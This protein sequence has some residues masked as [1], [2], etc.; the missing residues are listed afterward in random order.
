MGSNP[1]VRDLVTEW[2][3][4]SVSFREGCLFFLSLAGL[5]VLALKARVRLT[6]TELLWLAVFGWLA[7]SSVRAIVWWGL[8]L[9]PIATRLL[10][11]L[12]PDGSK[13]QT[14]Q[15]KPLLNL[16]IFAAILGMV[17]ASLPWLKSA[18]PILPED[19]RALVSAADTPVAVSEY[20]R[21][22]PPPPGRV[23]THLAWGGYFDWA[24]WP[25]FQP[26]LDGRIEIHPPQVWLDYLTITF[27]GA[28][29]Q[30][31][32]DQYAVSTVVL[33]RRAE[34]DLAR[35]LAADPGWRQTYE[36]DLA[37]VFVRA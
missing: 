21:T 27:P 16:V 25:T 9:A 11:S 34:A 14:A 7:I 18:M 10:G 19:K 13:P 28:E 22:N 6:L 35:L 3:P 12:A 2:A 36:D 20:L 31:L 23:F 5:L 26:F 1:I 32:L 17:V 15:E 29:W 24:S 30:S 33:D 4:T 37:V 8:V